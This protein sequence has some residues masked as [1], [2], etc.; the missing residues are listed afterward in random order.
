MRPTILL[1]HAALDATL[2]ARYEAAAPGWRILPFTSPFPGM[3]AAYSALA[4][5]LR[6]R[7]P[8]PLLDALLRH[9]RAEDVGPCVVA[10]FSAGYGLARE[11]AADESASR[12]AAWVGLDGMH[13]S[14]EADGTASDAG[15]AWLVKLAAEALEGRT[16]L[17]LG[18]SDVRTYGSTASTTDVAAEVRRLAGAP[19]G[20][21][22]VRAYNVATRDHD[23]H[24]AALRGWG[25]DLLGEAVALLGVAPGAPHAHGSATPT[26]TTPGGSHV[27]T[28][29]PPSTTPSP[30]TVPA[31]RPTPTVSAVLRRGHAGPGVVRLQTL[32]A[33]AGY[34]CQIDGIFGPKTE[35]AVRAFQASRGLAVD[36]LAGPRTLAALEALGDTDRPPPPALPDKPIDAARTLGVRRPLSEEQVDAIFGEVPWSPIAGDPSAIL[37]PA[38]WKKANLVTVKIPQLVGVGGAHR[39]GLV[40]VHR[41]IAEPMR[42]MFDAWEQRKK[43]GLIVNWG[44][45]VADRR[46]RNGTLVSRHARGIAFDLNTQPNWRGTPGAARGTYGSIV[47]LFEEFVEFGFASG[48]FY[49]IEDWMHGEGTG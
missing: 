1:A 44:G 47:E 8:G 33:S 32:L 25:P 4:A 45:T 48:G 34:P 19:R 11:L 23:E 5:D 12:V 35:V 3:S 17:T 21:F 10:W 43:L 22:V 14:R 31:A 16:V 36:G 13:T 49:P 6:R 29:A 41:L 28:P 7:Y 9:L 27:A 46:V 2:R 30:H 18:H 26:G 24:V 38:A 39:D 37:V 15:V 42:G 20:K 40:Q